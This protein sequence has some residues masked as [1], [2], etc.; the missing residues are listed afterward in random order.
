MSISQSSEVPMLAGS[1]ITLDTVIRPTGTYRVRSGALWHCLSPSSYCS[2]S[3]LMCLATTWNE[4]DSLYEYLYAVTSLSTWL[5]RIHISSFSSVS[6]TFLFILTPHVP[7]HYTQTRPFARRKLFVP[8]ARPVGKSLSS[9][10][11]WKRAWMWLVLTSRTAITR[12]MAPP[13]NVSDRQHAT[14]NAT[15][16]LCLT[17]RAQK[18]VPDFSP[19]TWR[20]LI[21]S[22]EKPSSWRRWVCGYWHCTNSQTEALTK[23]HLQFILSFDILGLPLQRKFTEVG[24]FVPC[25]GQVCQA[26]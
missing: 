14:S 25:L 10:F 22:R 7:H 26:R 23:M 16:P 2:G 15:W 3:H 1:F 4:C 5:I 20:R 8:S 17:P 24:L 6:S 11:W 13:W 18:F 12:V 9:R 21:W 19:M